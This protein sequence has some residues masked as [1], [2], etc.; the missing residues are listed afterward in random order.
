MD[1]NLYYNLIRYLD[2]LTIP[3]NFS[4]DEQR[5]LKTTARHYFVRDGLLYKKFNRQN[6]ERPLR[7][8]KQTEVEAILYNMHSDP[9]SGH[10]AFDGTFQRTYTR[11]YWPQMGEDI[12][13][14]INSCQTCQ[15]F[16]GTRRK[17][18]L[19]PIQ[20]GRP[21]DRVGMDLVGPLPVTK[22][23]NRYIIVIT[24]YLTKWPEA[25]PIPSKHAEI[26]AQHFHEEIICRHGCPKEILTD[27]GS[28]FQNQ[29]FNSL[30]N[31][32]GIRHKLSSAYHPQTNGL[33]ERFNRTLCNSLAK[34]AHERNIDWDLLIPSVLFAYRTMRHSTTRHTPFYLTYGRDA[35][36]PVE[37][38]YPT[39][40]VEPIDEEDN[41]LRHTYQL[42]DKLPPALIDAQQNISHSQEYSK[43]RLDNKIPDQI[44]LKIGD[45]VWL[46]RKVHSHKFAPKW[47]GPYHIHEVLHNSAYRLRHLHDETILPNTYHGTRLK[48]Y[49]EYKTMQPIIVIE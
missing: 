40:P 12:K 38:E 39:Y 22:Q 25:K 7:V 16:G 1:L 8:I 14:Y 46:E 26:V 24:E 6:S 35:T 11:Y 27:Q 29:F 18:P 5:K 44:P 33:T 48:L 10:F 37:F 19:H 28:E 34:L 4:L 17:E 47:L 21:Y 3:D 2:D 41:L 32:H 31:L 15:K 30:C 45:K 20:V 9:S 23:N 43:Q 13:N 36:L 49:K 42:I